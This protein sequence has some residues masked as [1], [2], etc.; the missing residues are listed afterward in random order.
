[1]SKSR[2]SLR[3]VLMDEFKV[4]A[5]KDKAQQSAINTLSKHPE[6]INRIFDDFPCLLPKETLQNLTKQFKSILTTVT[7][8]ADDSEKYTLDQKDKNTV[9]AFEKEIISIGISELLDKKGNIKNELIQLLNWEPY[10]KKLTATRYVLTEE[11]VSIMCAYVGAVNT[12]IMY[13]SDELVKINLPAFLATSTYV[14]P[15]Y[16]KWIEE[17][18]SLNGFIVLAPKTDDKKEKQKDILYWPIKTSKATRYLIL[19]SIL[20][21]VAYTCA[22][23]FASQDTGKTTEDLMPQ[24]ARLKF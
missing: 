11:I 2:Q 18:L 24:I 1:M 10:K 16:R 20:T 15:E 3:H 12:I 13:H 22:K 17:S 6:Y 23:K 4:T 7:P 14:N 8:H 5:V 19:G 21:A 9:L